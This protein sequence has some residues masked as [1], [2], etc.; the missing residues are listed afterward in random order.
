MGYKHDIFISYTHDAQMSSWVHQ[1]LVPFLQSYIGNAINRPVQL[2]IDREGIASGDA[3][4]LRLRNAL[5][6]SRSLLAIWSPLYFHSNWCR[7]ECAVML[8]RE[9]Q[10]G[11]RTVLQPK[12]LVAPIN[13]FDGQFFPEKARQIQYLDCRKY[14][15]VGEG[16][17]KT[18]RYV[19]FQELL[20]TWAMD[21]AAVIEG[22]PPWQDAWINEEWFE[23]PDNDLQPKPRDNFAF[24]G[25]E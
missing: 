21:V 17:V 12:G 24:A 18:E 13:V 16:F 25:L 2:F 4:P 14:W 3:W 5:A 7:R 9:A 23:V 20:Q 15:I 19:E 11:Y 6:H 1:H 10:L 8:Y 22:A